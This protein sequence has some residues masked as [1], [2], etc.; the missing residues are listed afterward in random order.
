MQGYDAIFT[1]NGPCGDCHS[2]RVD[3]DAKEKGISRYDLGRERYLIEAW[4][5]KE[6]YASHIREQWQSMGISV[7]YNHEAFTLDSKLNDAVNKVFIDLYNKGLIYRGKRI[8]NWDVLANTALSN[9]E[10]EHTEE[11]GHLYYIRYPFTEDTNKYLTVAT[12]RP[13]T[14]FGDQALMINPNDKRY[15]K[16]L[17]KTVYI[18]TTK[19]KIPIISDDYVDIS[20]GTGIV[21]V[22]P[23]HDQNDFLVGERHNLEM[24]LCMSET[25]IMNALAFSYEV[26]DRFE[27][28]T[29]LVKDLGDLKL[30][31]KIE[32]H[33]HNVGR[34][35]RTG[36]IVEPRLSLNGFVKMK[37]LAKQAIEKS[38]AKFYPARFEK[39]FINWMENIEDW[40]ISRQ[41]WWGHKFLFGI[42]VMKCVFK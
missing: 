1:R 39:T 3:A 17:G 26:M 27:C 38:T 35:E 9:I 5:W 12:T 13:E 4:K 19:T 22:T 6:E 7:D 23:A 18:P 25:G 20:F 14:M 10:V 32:P 11:Q 34:S 21:K 37:P 8:I 40:C 31:E 16:Y 24:P 15:K 42:R 29:K 36:V 30:L 2:S 28:R 33:I 41:L